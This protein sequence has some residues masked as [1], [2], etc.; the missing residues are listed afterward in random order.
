MV[1]R[2]RIL[3]FLGAKVLPLPFYHDPIFTLLEKKKP[4]VIQMI[5]AILGLKIS[6]RE[7]SNHRT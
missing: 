7:I 1:G 3:L 6:S 2:C 4:S 5:D